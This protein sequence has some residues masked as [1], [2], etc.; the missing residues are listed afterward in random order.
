MPV[1]VVDP[2]F[3]VKAYVIGS[4]PPVDQPGLASMPLLKSKSNVAFGGEAE[5][6]GE[7]GAA[8]GGAAV[9]GEAVGGAAVGGAAGVV[10]GGDWHAFAP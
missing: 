7:G 1:D 2:S 4:P 6:G 3:F 5:D 10:E 8:V 9:G